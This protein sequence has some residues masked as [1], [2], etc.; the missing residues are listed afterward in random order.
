MIRENMS[1]WHSG[2]NKP[3][4]KRFTE[5]TDPESSYPHLIR[6]LKNQ[7]LSEVPLKTSQ[8]IQEMLKQKEVQ[9]QKPPA[10]QEN[11]PIQSD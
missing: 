7:D 1:N 4:D 8:R 2:E 11:I 3:D 9:N 5:N 6:A 10:I